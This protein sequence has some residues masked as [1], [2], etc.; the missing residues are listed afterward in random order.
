MSFQFCLTISSIRRYVSSRDYD[1][2]YSSP[3][4]APYEEL[5]HNIEHSRHH[6]FVFPTLQAI[7]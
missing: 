5:F 3:S 4:Q 2:Q 7:V 1:V 6:G